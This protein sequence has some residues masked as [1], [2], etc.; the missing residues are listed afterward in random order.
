MR[1][2]SDDNSIKEI[3]DVVIFEKEKAIT[4]EHL[5]SIKLG[6]IMNLNWI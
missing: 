4:K 6:F 2:D 5:I 3:K 1:I